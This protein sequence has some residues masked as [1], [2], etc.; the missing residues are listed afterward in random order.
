M[1]VLRRDKYTQQS[2]HKEIFTDFMMNMDINPD[3]GDLYRNVNLYAIQT[4]LKALMLTDRGERLFQED[5]GSSIKDQI[6]ELYTSETVEVLKNYIKSTIDSFEPRVA[7][8]DCTIVPTED[9][10]GIHITIQFSTVTNP[11]VIAD[12]TV[13]LTRVR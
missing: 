6:F 8:I 4:S 2:K 13:L 12:V 5:V 7:Y 3:T 1:T 10:N 11:G 9:S